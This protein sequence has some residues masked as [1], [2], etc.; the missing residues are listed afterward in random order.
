MNNMYIY[1]CIYHTYIYYVYIYTHTHIHMFCVF[2]VEA[3][4]KGFIDRYTLDQGIFL[5]CLDT[6]QIKGYS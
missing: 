5:F 1:V 4:Q 3:K 2:L 6:P